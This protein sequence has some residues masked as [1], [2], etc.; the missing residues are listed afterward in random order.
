VLSVLFPLPIYVAAIS[1]AVV[2]PIAARRLEDPTLHKNLEWFFLFVATQ[3]VL[4]GFFAQ[5]LA[6]PSTP[7]ANLVD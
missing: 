2:M 6:D 3:P 7:L 5:A 1:G 4:Q